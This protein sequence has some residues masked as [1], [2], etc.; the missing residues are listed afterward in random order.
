MLRSERR[1]AQG[2]VRPALVIKMEPLADADARL[3]TVGACGRPEDWPSGGPL[4]M[5]H[6]LLY[7]GLA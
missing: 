4:R 6:A 5:E 3:E 7:T 2:L 1:L